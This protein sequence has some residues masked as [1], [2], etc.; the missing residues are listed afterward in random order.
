[1]RSGVLNGSALPDLEIAGFK[2]DNSFPVHPHRADL[3]SEETHTFRLDTRKAKR[4]A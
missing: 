1:M 4:L 3:T 2:V